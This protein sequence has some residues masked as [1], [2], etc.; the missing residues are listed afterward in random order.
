[1]GECRVAAYLIRR[2]AGF[3]RLY[4]QFDKENKDIVMGAELKEAKMIIKMA[5]GR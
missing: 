2:D 4:Q 5:R 3:Y 1:M